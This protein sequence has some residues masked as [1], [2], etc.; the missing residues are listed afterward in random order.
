MRERCASVKQYA[1]ASESKSKSES[2][3]TLF[4]SEG[5]NWSCG[6]GPHSISHFRRRSRFG[7]SIFP[8]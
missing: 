5:S 1:T 2:E 6:G 8:G 4:H 3:L 7:G